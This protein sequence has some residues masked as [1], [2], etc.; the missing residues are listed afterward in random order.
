MKENNI[1]PSKVIIHAPYI[2]NL[3]NLENLK[4]FSKNIHKNSFHSVN[5]LDF[6]Y[7]E[8]FPKENLGG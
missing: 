8:F 4:P 3:G 6:V 1:D 2:V 7:R 5:I